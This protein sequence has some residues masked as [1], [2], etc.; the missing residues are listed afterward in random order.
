M[1]NHN[2]YRLF[3]YSPCKYIFTS[4]FEK[5]IR[6]KEREREANIFNAFVTFVLSN[7]PIKKNDSF[8]KVESTDKSIYQ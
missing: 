7:I 8:E 1:L 3:I 2:V 4:N 6:K 5:K